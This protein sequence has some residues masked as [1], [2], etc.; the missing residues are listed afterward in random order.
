MCLL[1]NSDSLSEYRIW[2]T[3][4]YVSPKHQ[5][6]G[7]GQNINWRDQYLT[8]FQ[9]SMRDSSKRKES[10]GLGT[11]TIHPNF[12]DPVE[13]CT[14]K[15]KDTSKEVDNTPRVWCHGNQ[16][17]TASRSSYILALGIRPGV[18]LQYKNNIVLHPNLKLPIFYVIQTLFQKWMR[19]VITG[20]ER[21]RER[22]KEN[23]VAVC[24][25]S[26]FCMP[27]IDYHPTKEGFVISTNAKNIYG[28]QP[29]SPKPL[30]DRTNVK[31][32]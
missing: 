13:S 26:P 7:W 10:K 1:E 31:K 30:W 15:L 19:P 12:R 6:R 28:S 16:T 3:V 21:G 25:Q 14:K 32:K 8:F 29:S 23:H 17:K 11:D 22:R 5:G 2:S 18:C 4:G 27:R 9:Y 24:N 20:G